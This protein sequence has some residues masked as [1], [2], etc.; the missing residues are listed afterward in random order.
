MKGNKGNVICGSQGKSIPQSIFSLDTWGS[1]LIQDTGMV[2]F[3]LNPKNVIYVKV[4]S[5]K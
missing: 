1:A 5:K 4:V 3:S 2:T